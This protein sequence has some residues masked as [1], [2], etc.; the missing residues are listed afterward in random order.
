[1]LQNEIYL[2]CYSNYPLHVYEILCVVERMLFL[3]R[4]GVILSQF[5]YW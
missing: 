5:F 3:I 2:P 4:F 1:M